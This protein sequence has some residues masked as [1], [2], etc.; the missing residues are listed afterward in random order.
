MMLS[1]HHVSARERDLSVPEKTTLE[2]GNDPQ[3]SLVRTNDQQYLSPVTA[4]DT[5]FTHMLLRWEG[6]PGH[7]EH[8]HHAEE[9]D[10][11]AEDMPIM[12]E[13]RSSTDN[14]TWSDWLVVSEDPDLLVPEDGTEVFWSQVI[15]AGADA[16]FW[17]VRAT[18]NPLDDGSLPVLRQVDVNTVDGRYAQDSETAVSPKSYQLAD[19]SKPPVMSRSGWGCPD[20][21]GSRVPPAY[22]PVKHMVVHHTVDANS[23]TSRE[24]NWGDR[25]RAI[26][27]F[28]TLTRGWGD[29]GYNYLVAPDGTIFEGR[30]GGDDAVGFHDTGNYGSMGVSMIGTY[31]TVSPTGLAQESLVSL[32]A[33]KA[34]QKGIDPLGSSYY[35]GCDISYYCS[36]PGAVIFNIA[37]HRHVYS[38][39][40]PG[41]ATAALLPSIRNR[42]RERLDGGGSPVVPDNGDLLIDELESSFA[43]SDATW[44][45]AACGYGGHTFYTFATDN[46]DESTNSATWRPTI[47]ETGRYRVYAS[48]PQSCGIAQ[49]PYATRQTIYRI[50]HADGNAERTVDQNTAEE[51]IDLGAYTFNE[52]TDGAVELYD[53][54]G[55]P[56][57]EGRVI[58]FDS[59][60][61]VAEEPTAE[62][63]LVDVQYG[64]TRVA[65]G[66]LL[67]VTFTVRNTGEVPIYSQ[68]PEAGTRP[69]GS[70]DP[71]EGYVYDEAE[72][73]LG[74]N[75]QSYPVYAKETERIRVTLGSSDVRLLCNG[76]TG[77][78]PWRW[79]INGPL[80]P[81]E[82]REIR[83]AI[84][85]R[86]PGEVSLQAGLIQEFVRYYTQNVFQET[87]TVTPERQPP[88]V[89]SY[90][91]SLAPLAHVYA[92]QPMPANFLGRTH[93][94]L[95]IVQG[96]YLG[97]FD[98]DGSLTEWGEAGPLDG[99]D[100]TFIIEQTRVFRAPRD[101]EYTFSTNTDDG[102]WLWVNGR[103]VVDNSGLHPAR[104]VTGKV[105]LT[106][107]NHILS[108]RYFD[109]T[110][111]ATAGYAVKM[112]NDSAFTGLLDALSDEPYTSGAFTTPP[113]L[114]LAADDQGGSGTAAIRYSWDGTNWEQESGNLVQLSS[115]TDNG[116]YRLRYQGIDASGNTSDERELRF[117][118]QGEVL[119]APSDMLLTGP[120]SGNALSNHFFT[121]QISPDDTAIPVTYRWEAT[122]LQQVTVN[123]GLTNTVRLSWQTS[124]VKT[125]TVTASN[126]N[127]TVTAT[128]T[129]VINAVPAESAEITIDPAAQSILDFTAIQGQV[130][131]LVLPIGS[132]A[133]PT[134]LIYTEF[135]GPTQPI[136]VSASL[137]LA[138]RAFQL[139]AVTDDGSPYESFSLQQ[140]MTMTVSY[141]N[142]GLN[143]GAFDVNIS[144]QEDL[145]LLYWDGVGWQ[146]AANTCDPA[147]LYSLGDNKISVVLCP[148]TATMPNDFVLVE[149][150]SLKR[151]YLPVIRR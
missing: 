87:I 116:E 100:D 130:T 56:L 4:A 22:Y 139:Q 136:N 57:S 134:R 70:F 88:V 37:G 149:Q 113:T 94:P 128:T 16:R 135:T 47:P 93:N 3:T 46:A 66:E 29:V 119:P 103:L 20:G 48:A 82:T 50:R 28:H 137:R 138:G 42:V 27:S 6:S 60:K 145:R 124:G 90:D 1:Q 97:S 2:P 33:W 34:N 21:Q 143:N 32:L 61:W 51:W 68:R 104:E 76:E 24:S 36:A 74:D 31:D 101:G 85:F 79:G 127:G 25:V 35:Y 75:Q 91:E 71:A 8:E 98:W 72:C 59:I 112:P 55:E 146:D 17:Q 43:R 39:G 121:A 108:F 9:D 133:G 140:P 65:A 126:A 86:T 110:G 45:S 151:V 23:L 125:V 150:V 111:D 148:T 81:G 114:T 11:A 78:Y 67:E 54:T 115:P 123:G 30:S 52:G 44:Y 105:T 14:Q 84:R 12:L 99:V 102:S 62:A 18:L 5:P 63:E 26:W 109:L 73:F 7:T 83:G 131:T 58:F 15:Y 19:L 106:R 10:H 41:N 120:S 147:S 129:M 53:L 132:V 107:G 40:C 92:L 89:S 117:V 144:N 122:D 142:Q 38:T 77:G 141:S 80:D 118:V 96:E 69:D 64:A 49:P 13:V 95:S